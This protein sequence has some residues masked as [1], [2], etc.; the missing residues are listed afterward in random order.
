[1]SEWPTLLDW[2]VLWKIKSAW[3]WT[4]QVMNHGYGWITWL[5]TGRQVCHTNVQ[6]QWPISPW[7]HCESNKSHP[8]YW[9]HRTGWKARVTIHR[10]P[11]WKTSTRR[12][13]PPVTRSLH[14][15]HQ[16]L[17]TLPFLLFLARMLGLLKQNT[18]E[19]SASG[20][21]TSSVSDLHDMT[22]SVIEIPSWSAAAGTFAKVCMHDS[23]C[24]CGGSGC[25]H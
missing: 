3:T 25:K 7:I 14:G 5:V 13:R 22:N 8:Y 6:L 15:T 12:D 11:W 2:S 20:F 21:Y 4:L 19:S 1:M 23:V 18:V 16:K 9:S 24:R 17:L 10:N